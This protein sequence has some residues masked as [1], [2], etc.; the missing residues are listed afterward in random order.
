MY[1]EQERWSDFRTLLEARQ[2]ASS[3]QR[4]RLELLDQIAE[5]DETLLEDLPHAI[6]VLNTRL[7][8]DPKVGGRIGPWNGS[9]P[10]R[11]TGGGLRL[12]STGRKAFPHHRMCQLWFCAGRTSTGTSSRICPAVLTW[13]NGF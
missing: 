13:P 1:R 8:L 10:N 2:A 12:C 3:D 9:T 4:E 7:D 11:K 6:E 5:V